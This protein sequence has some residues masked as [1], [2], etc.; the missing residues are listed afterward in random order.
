[1]AKFKTTP[2]TKHPTFVS[3]V[4]LLILVCVRP[5]QAEVKLPSIFSDHAVLQRDMKVPVWGWDDPG[6]EVH[7]AVAGQTQK[8][9]ADDQGKWRV[10]LEPLSVSKEP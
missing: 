6:E 8:A 3:A 9:T 5:I 1:M 10:T 7:V 4:T 2:V